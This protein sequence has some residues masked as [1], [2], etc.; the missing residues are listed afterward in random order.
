[1]KLLK[2]KNVNEAQEIVVGL[3][4]TELAQEIATH[5]PL[6]IEMEEYGGREYC[7][8]KLPFVPKTQVENQTYFDIGDF[9]YWG[10]GNALAF[11]YADGE[12]KSVPSGIVVIGKILS[13]LSAL[14]N[15]P[16]TI[17]VE[18]TIVNDL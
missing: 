5:L 6:L 17:K 2:I 11:F 8:N 7:G 18:L 12:S 15:M 16:N 9:V 4:D 14:K 3:Y 13:N 10:K 1:M